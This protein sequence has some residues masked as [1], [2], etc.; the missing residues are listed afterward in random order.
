MVFK[1]NIKDHV[2]ECIRTSN[3]NEHKQHALFGRVEDVKKEK[4]QKTKKKKSRGKKNTASPEL[5]Q[6]CT[7]RWVAGHSRHETLFDHVQEHDSELHDAHIN[8]IQGS[9]GGGGEGGGGG[10]TGNGRT[11]IR[12]RFRLGSSHP[13]RRQKSP[14]KKKMVVSSNKKKSP[15]SRKDVDAVP[16]LPSS[17]EQHLW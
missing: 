3:W 12:P 15:S 2:D 8:I 16:V 5:S 6:R 7:K 17:R 9:S 4:K 14:R 10:G 1:K 11:A 13:H